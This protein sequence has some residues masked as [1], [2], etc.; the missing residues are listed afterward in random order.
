MNLTDGRNL[1]KFA[2]NG[3]EELFE[4]PSMTGQAEKSRQIPELSYLLKEVERV[5]GRTIRTTNDFEAL[6]I[7]IERETESIIS[8]STLKRLWGYVSLNPTP[9]HSTL[10][11][12]SRYV[13]KRDFRAFCDSL[14]KSPEFESMFFTAKTISVHDL[15]AG[16]EVTI[17]WNPNRLVTLSYLGSYLFEVKQS[18]NSK[19]EE[20]DRF[21]LVNIMLGY[22]LYI[23]RILRHGEYTPAFVAGRIE[24]LSLLKVH[25][26]EKD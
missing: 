3:V 25:S 8:S 12:L 2:E 1:L 11:I 6:S 7:L 22:P 23:S 21:E 15:K 14:K 13:G 24:G 26:P 9:R 18:L 16:S 5:Y 19:L 20:G 4:K 10:D 17:G